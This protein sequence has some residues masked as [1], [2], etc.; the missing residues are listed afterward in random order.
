MQTLKVVKKKF[1]TG[2]AAEALL[3]DPQK[4]ISMVGIGV[5]PYQL[6]KRGRR[7]FGFKP[8]IWS[9]RQVLGLAVICALSQSTRHKGCNTDYIKKTMH[10]FESMSQGAF[11]SWLAE[12][13]TGQSTP[14]TEEGLSTISWE[15]FPRRDKVPGDEEI[16]ADMKRRLAK[17]EAMILGLPMPGQPVDRVTDVRKLGSRVSG[18]SE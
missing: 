7:R 15:G 9:A 1:T 12:G 6:G 3:V 11:L 16:K 13:Q 2:E 18:G 17:V 4:L 10:L 5:V 14:Y 8:H